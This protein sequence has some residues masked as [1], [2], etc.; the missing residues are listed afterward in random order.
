[1]KNGSLSYRGEMIKPFC[2]GLITSSDEMP[3]PLMIGL[4]M[5]QAPTGLN[6]KWM[7]KTVFLHVEMK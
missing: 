6:N 7:T 4:I 3:N 2:I 1:M 5:I